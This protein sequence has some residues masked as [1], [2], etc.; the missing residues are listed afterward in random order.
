ML[1]SLDEYLIA[2]TP[3]NV[4]NTPFTFGGKHQDSPSTYGLAT[5][6]SRY[7]GSRIIEH[8]GKCAGF[9]STVI[10]FPDLQTGIAIMC[11][12]REAEEL[13]PWI[14]FTLVDKIIGHPAMNWETR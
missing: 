5:W 11:N 13:I 2:A 7:N 10:R 1:P 4:P 3:M 9:R 14:K 8:D 12:S 6:Q